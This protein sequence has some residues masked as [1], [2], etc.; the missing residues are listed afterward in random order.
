[1]TLYYDLETSDK[2]VS[3]CQIFQMA[4]IGPSGDLNLRARRQ[5]WIVP[6]PEAL[7]ITRIDPDTLDDPQTP[8]LFETLR[9]F[10]DTTDK[11]GLRA[12]YNIAHYDESV[13]TA[14][15][16]QNLLLP[17]NDK[18]AGCLDV[19]KAVHL[20]LMQRPGLLNFALKTASGNVS[21]AL[22]NTCRQNGITLHENDAHDALA[23]VRATMALADLIKQKD[24]DLW[25]HVERMSSVAGVEHFVSENDIFYLNK[26]H[27]GK[28]KI[29]PLAPLGE[30][31]ADN[32]NILCFDLSFDPASYIS[33]TEG[34]ILSCLSNKK[35]DDK[36]P[37]ILIA[38]NSCPAIV[39]E[40]LTSDATCPTTDQ[41][42]D[43]LNKTETLKSRPDLSKKI[44]AALDK[45]ESLKPQK[46]DL[47]T[48]ILPALPG[49]LA[50]KINQWQSDFH[51][52][53]WQERATMTRQFPEDFAQ[54]LKE[55]PSIKFYHDCA[56]RIIFDNV[57]EMM[58]PAEREAFRTGIY[59]RITNPLPPEGLMTLP[60]ARQE[61]T[62]IRDEISQKK[63]RFMT[64]ADLPTLDRLQ[65]Y[66]NRLEIR[67]APPAAT[68]RPPQ[69]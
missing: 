40:I 54:E 65:E 66:Y 36:N 7:V 51:A 45:I 41:K 15:L 29:V 64:D 47:E 59:N 53:N 60:A 13:L 55:H 42:I 21:T 12:G 20:C 28:P 27:F 24:P 8:T 35:K 68:L 34:Q 6:A 2:D 32:E 61:I 30:W 10:F 22:G 9:R 49:T 33:M 56:R 43:Y 14:A 19:I 48:R 50:R 62:R 44:S 4:A 23:D 38:K 58:E 16:R 25:I 31:G 3:Y 69:P 5:A 1:M 18:S 26:I 52:K 37:F 63:H 67:Y 11:D 39:S 17:A 46:T 57:P